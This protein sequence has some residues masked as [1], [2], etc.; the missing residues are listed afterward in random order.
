MKVILRSDITNV[1]RQGDIKDVADG[2][3]RNYLFPQK[4]AMEASTGNMKLWER[5]KHTLEK[6]RD[7]IIATA[8]ELA[9]KI[10]AVSVMITVKVGDAGKLFGSVANTNIAR[11]LGENGF[12]IEKHAILLPEPIKEVGAYTVDIRLHPEV[13]AKAKVWVVA[14]KSHEHTAEPEQE[15][16]PEDSGESK[17]E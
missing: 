8:K 9:Q 12:T 5:Q 13:I 15:A 1:G 2:F 7:Q 10:E 3:A 14:E 16:A 4:L 11:A 17:K 6:E